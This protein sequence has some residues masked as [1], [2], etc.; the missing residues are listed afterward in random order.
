VILHSLA[1]PIVVVLC[2]NVLRKVIAAGIIVI[3]AK[4]LSLANRDFSG[5]SVRNLHLAAEHS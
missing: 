3:Q 5:R 1:V 2:V 4:R